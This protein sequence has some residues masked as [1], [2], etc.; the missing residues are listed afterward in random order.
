MKSIAFLTE[1]E[2]VGGGMTDKFDERF[3]HEQA[4]RRC[5]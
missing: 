1:K 4:H 5:W 3:L 2:C